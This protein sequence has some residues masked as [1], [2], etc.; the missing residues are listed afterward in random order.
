VPLALDVGTHPI[1]TERLR[2]LAKERRS[3]GYR[4][5]HNRMRAMRTKYRK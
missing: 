3:F 5:T 4:R 1:S 2:T